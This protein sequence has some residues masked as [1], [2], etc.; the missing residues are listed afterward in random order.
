[1]L[2]S[3]E[4]SAE[5]SS[6]TENVCTYFIFGFKGVLAGIFCVSGITG[7]MSTYDSL[8]TLGRTELY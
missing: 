3:E 4:E 8:F 5:T 6:N 2:L 1:M 7:A